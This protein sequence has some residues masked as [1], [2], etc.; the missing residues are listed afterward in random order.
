LPAKLKTKKKIT[1]K[2]K[3][4]H[5]SAQ[6]FVQQSVTTLWQFSPRFLFILCFLVNE[7]R[8]QAAGVLFC[9][10]PLIN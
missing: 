7:L 4:F 2:L 8:G 6:M 1:K 5:F 9:F 3:A 10:C